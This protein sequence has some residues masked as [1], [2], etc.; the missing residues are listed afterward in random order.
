MEEV[1]SELFSSDDPSMSEEDCSAL[2]EDLDENPEG[3]FD[4]GVVE[5]VYNDEFSGSGRIDEFREL[6]KSGEVRLVY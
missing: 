6:L 1:D 4:S 3:Y 5:N 2:A